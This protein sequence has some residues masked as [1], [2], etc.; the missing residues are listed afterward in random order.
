MSY[1]D[2]YL[3][4]INLSKDEYKNIRFKYYKKKFGDDLEYFQFIS[5]IRYNPIDIMDNYLYYSIV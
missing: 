3:K 4:I 5:M 1:I 2:D